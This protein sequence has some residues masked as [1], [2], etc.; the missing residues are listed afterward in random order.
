MSDTMTNEQR[1]E[2]LKGLGLSAGAPGLVD[3]QAPAKTIH[4]PAVTPESNVTLAP[5]GLD[6]RTMPV[7]EI[8]FD[9]RLLDRFPSLE[10]DGL[11]A[12][13][14]YVF[15][16]YKSYGRNKERNS[17]LHRRITTFITH[18]RRNRQTGGMVKEK[19]KTTKDDRDLAALIASQ[20]VNATDLAE[21]LALL[22]E[23]KKAQG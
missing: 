5:Q 3:L 22:A 19:I 2:F 9:D 20:G 18:A 23:A 4:A 15:S 21:A 12:A 14:D 8:V 13:S 17:L 7:D 16:L 10:G 11:K 6:P 1:A